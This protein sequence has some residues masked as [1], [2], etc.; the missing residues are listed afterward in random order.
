M[1]YRLPALAL[2]LILSP[3]AS[4]SG[5]EAAEQLTSATDATPQ[6]QGVQTAMKNLLQA[7]KGINSEESATAALPAV[8][9]AV[10]EYDTHM[11][12]LRQHVKEIPP[13][14]LQ[15]L[16]ETYRELR[17]IGE[18]D[19]FVQWVWMNEALMY[20]LLL[21]SAHLPCIMPEETADYMLQCLS[22]EA[23]HPD[24]AAGAQLETLRTEAAERHAAFMAAHPADYAG[25]NGA[26]TT[27]AIILRPLVENAGSQDDEERSEQSSRLIRAYMHQVYPWAEFGYGTW[28]ACPDGS[29]YETQVLF[30]GLYNRSNGE[31]KV[32]KYPVYFR[33]KAPR[34]QK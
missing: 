21:Q 16:R 9:A 26:D 31:Q 5:Q 18:S 34:K 13:Q 33:L 15:S 8:A 14:H 27:S 25:G 24:E 10:H 11:L 29:F 3:L 30:P 1:V 7:L 28:T 20:H 32:L 12:V 22:M 6:A 4:A 23:H 19:D 2:A 17:T